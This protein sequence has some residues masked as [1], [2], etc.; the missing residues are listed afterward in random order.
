MHEEHPEVLQSWVYPQERYD[1]YV[2]SDY[3]CS[4]QLDYKQGCISV[5]HDSSSE[6]IS[7]TLR[8]VG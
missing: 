7:E 2:A 1:G 4:D 6:R 3:V 8:P 5:T